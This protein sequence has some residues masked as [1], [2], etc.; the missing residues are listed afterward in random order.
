MCLIDMLK[1]RSATLKY[2]SL[3]IN[4]TLSFNNHHFHVQISILISTNELLY[5]SLE[6]KAQPCI[7]LS[8]SI[9]SLELRELLKEKSVLTEPLPR[10]I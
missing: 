1:V 3:N 5:N 8:T 6:T 4:S 2:P 10:V 9:R 7:I